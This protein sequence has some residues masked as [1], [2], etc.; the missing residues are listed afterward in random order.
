MNA[1]KNVFEPS[2][3]DEKYFRLVE[4][5]IDGGV[6][7]RESTMAHALLR[8]DR[9]WFLPEERRDHAHVDAPIAIPGGQ[10]NS[11]PTTVA[12]MLRELAVQS[13]ESVLDV[14]FGS[15]WTTALL[16][17]LVGDLGKVWGIETNTDT[18]AFGKENIARFSRK[19]GIKNI[20]IIQEDGKKGLIEAAPFNR[21]LV[22]AAAD[23]VPDAL[24]D[25]LAPG[26]RIVIP[27]RD[28]SSESLRVIEKDRG[29]K[30]SARDIPGFRFVPLV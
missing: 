18:Y 6:I 5:L 27:V 15:G 17:V 4:R 16:A 10:T 11:Q 13:G 28:G 3:P 21:I 19:S 2:L 14:G 22:S 12:I 29:R 25:Q 9:S 20:E 7:V 8:V 24:L 1:M 26:G 23:A 30:V